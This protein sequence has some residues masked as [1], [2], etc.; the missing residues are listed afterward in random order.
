MVL[1]TTAIVLNTC[2]VVLTTSTVVRTTTTGVLST[3][4][5][6]LATTTD[7]CKL[8]L[9]RTTATHKQHTSN[10]QAKHKPHDYPNTPQSQ[11]GPTMKEK[12]CFVTVGTTSFDSLIRQFNDDANVARVCSLLKQKGINKLTLQIGHQAHM[13]SHTHTHTRHHG[14]RSFLLSHTRADVTARARAR[15]VRVHAPEYT[16]ARAC[17]WSTSHE[18][19]KRVE[20]MKRP[21]CVW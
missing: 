5:V 2:T 1:S 17:S 10:T 15:V 20:M 3:I 4:I 11:S 7:Y 18:T 21:M 12:S 6:V 19:S 16:A 14:A 9:L 13:H 8:S